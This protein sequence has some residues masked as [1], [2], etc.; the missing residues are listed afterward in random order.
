MLEEVKIETHRGTGDNTHA[1]SNYQHISLVLQEQN[2]TE[3]AYNETV[4][5]IT[6]NRPKSRDRTRTSITMKRGMVDS[7]IEKLPDLNATNK[8]KALGVNDE[9]VT[10]NAA[11]VKSCGDMNKANK[12]GKVF[13][14]LFACFT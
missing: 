7:R 3:A 10:N 5:Q 12:K 9:M 8:A 14:G 13:C 11:P 6:I 1:R 4:Q 2:K